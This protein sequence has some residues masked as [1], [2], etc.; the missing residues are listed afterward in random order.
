MTRPFLLFVAIATTLALLAGCEKYEYID[1]KAQQEAEIRLLKEFYKTTT[2]DSIKTL[3]NDSI[4]DLSGED[5]TGMFFVRKQEGAGDKI[6]LG[7]RVGVRYTQYVITRDSTQTA[8]MENT[9]ADN[10]ASLDPFTFTAGSG[11]IRGLDIAVQQMSLGGKGLVILPTAYWS[12]SGYY[13]YSSYY[14]LIFDF[15]ITYL[16]K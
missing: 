13:G 10:L 1:Y 11:S 4:F 6:T 3:P 16:E 7:K 5:S 8:I 15:E 2:F 14:T 9:D 12:S